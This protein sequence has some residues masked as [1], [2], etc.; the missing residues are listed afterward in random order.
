MLDDEGLGITQISKDVV[1]EIETALIY[2]RFSLTLT[3]HAK[4]GSEICKLVHLNFR[5]SLCF[6]SINQNIISLY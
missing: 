2:T 1:V 6:I 4:D 3:A 5:G